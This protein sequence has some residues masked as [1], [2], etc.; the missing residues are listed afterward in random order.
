MKPAAIIARELTKRY[1]ELEAVRGV[2]FEVGSGEVVGFLGPNGAGKTT[3]VRMLSCF[4]PPTAGTASIHGLD[5][6]ERP[7]D[8]KRLIGVCPQ[9]DNLDPDFNVLKNLL[10]YG[11]YFG[12]PS[13]T[14]RGRALELL[15]FVALSD[16]SRAPIQALS[17]GMK[18]RLILARALLNEPRV[19]IL[20]EPTTGLDPQARHAIW[21]RVRGLRAHGTTVLLTTHYME[22]A[23][24]LCDRVVVMDDGQI[25]LEGAPLALVEREVG[26]TVVEAWNYGEEFMEFMRALKG[27]LEE[28][29]DR[30][31]FYP[32]EGDHIERLLEERFPQQERLI[33]RAT[34]EDVFLKLTGRALR[35]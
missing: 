2:S 8:V 4:L 24:Q 30:L 5:V 34:L 6:R 18:R 27:R 16:K 3:T 35:D 20:D 14:V 22:E 26:R 31:Y 19:L 29:G 25:L 10:V 15:E 13:R 9:E 11:R 33:R 12:L 23:T 7:R 28:V 21:T 32:Q 17:G 1:G